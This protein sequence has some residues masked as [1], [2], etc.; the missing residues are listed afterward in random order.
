MRKL[1]YLVKY[2]LPIA[3]LFTLGVVLFSPDRNRD[4]DTVIYATYADIKDWDPASAF[5]L[6]VLALANIYEPLVYYSPSNGEDPIRPALA[7]EWSVSDDGLVWTFLLRDGVRFH[8]GTELTAEAAKLSLE[9]TISL[10]KGGAYI[11]S[12]V[13]SI[14]APDRLTLEIHTTYPAPIDLIAS[15]QYAAYIYSP[16]A[17]ENG[18]E[19]FNT[20]KAAGT[21]PYRFKQWVRNQQIVLEKNSDYWGGWQENQINRV[22]FKI[23]RESATQVQ[24]IL[25]GEADF[26]SLVPLD[27]LDA[28]A[29][30]GSIQ[31][32]Y[33]PSWKNSQFLINTSKTP[34]DNLHF[35]KA[36]IHSW[37][38]NAVVQEIYADS[39]DV[40]RGIIPKSLWG[41]DDSLPT[42]VFDL[43]LAK[44]H[45]EA[46][47]IPPAERKISISYI[48][49]SLAYQ[50]AAELFQSNLT[51]IGIQAELQPG[52][53]GT[54]WSAAKSQ[55]TAPNLISMTW[56]PT[57]ATPSDWLIGLFRT[58]S[59]ANFNLS[60]Y[61]NSHYDSLVDAGLKLEAT[62]R[63]TAVRKYHEAQ[64]ILVQDAVA[65]FYA[66]LKERIV[67][68]SDLSGVD[69][70]PAY[71]AVF[72]HKLK[73]IS[74]KD[75]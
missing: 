69:S 14:H 23:V 63:S 46:S 53:W 62:D 67:H 37:D 68:S 22:I 6:E 4:A 24:L 3:L 52:P 11:W 32:D 31:V 7:K 36:L 20:G 10:G 1:L 73:R 48:A 18:S 51:K 56:W 75:D 65:V 26:V 50:S 15:S 38:Y 34:T 70:N 12:A 2:A 40:S 16:Q 42:P 54:I 55:E 39:A 17:A 30:Q 25:A 13:D 33:I 57:Y 43:E 71:N 66:D 49:S 21:G 60:Y 72:F 8:D 64:Q 44:R 35:R 5:S 61:S 27:L 41:H 29:K 9:R 45:L 47:E 58:E 28:L 74:A 19:W 59:P